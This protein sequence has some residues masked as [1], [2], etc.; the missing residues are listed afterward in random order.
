MRVNLVAM[1]LLLPAV[2]S[3]APTMGVY[4]DRS[5]TQLWATPRM[6]E[7]FQ[8]YVYG[9]GID[10]YLDAAEF[11]VTVPSGLVIMGYTVPQGSL[12]LG[13]LPQGISITYWPPR[14]TWDPGYN[15]LCTIDFI[16]VGN[17]CWCP[18][19]GTAMDLVLRII[20]HPDSH[21][22]LGSCW[23]DNYLFNFVGLYSVVC[24]STLCM[25]TEETS[26]GAVKSLYR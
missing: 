26:W 13:T 14:D 22:I 19:G 15:L 11:A 6:W 3:A 18:Y 7:Q 8:A 9:K 21:G 23:P 16:Y 2:L 17:Q 20:P 24:P 1:I 25:G 10:C 5:A 4:F 12:T